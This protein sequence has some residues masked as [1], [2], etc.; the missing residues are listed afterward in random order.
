MKQSSMLKEINCKNFI[1]NPIKFSSG[2]NSI[3]GDNYSTN[4]IGKSTLLMIIDF[5]FGGN[6]YLTK[7]SGSI[8]ELGDLVFNFEFEFNSSSYFYNRG[9]Q[10]DNTIMVCDDQYNPVSEIDLK[11][12]TQRLKEMYNIENGLSFRA[13]VSP[14]SRIWGKG[15]YDVDKPIQNFSKE[16]ESAA[17]DNFI[18]LFNLFDSISKTSG[19]IKS[20]EESK[21]ILQGLHKKNYVQKVTKT[22]FQKNENEIKRIGEDINKIKDNLL[23]FTLNIEEL[24]NKELIELK[25]EKSKL[26]ENQSLVQNKIT[27][28]ELNIDRKSVKSNYFKKLSLFFENPNEEKINE[29]ESFHNK[30]RDILTREL[31]ATLEVLDEEN[32]N[33]SS[34]IEIID[35]K[36]SALLENVDSPK[37][38]VEKIY[39]LTIESNKIETVNRFYQEKINVEEDLNSLNETLLSTITDILN[40]IEE[41]INNELIRINKEIHTEKKKIPRIKLNRKSYSF[42]HSANTGTGKSYADLIEFDL[43][44][45]KLT[46]LPFI[47]HDSILFKNIEDVSVEKIIQQYNSFKKQIFIALDGINRYNDASQKILNKSS[48]IN[49]SE[50]RKLFNRDWR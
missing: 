16:P 49:L 39:D 11:T 44:I 45:L 15:N 48:V 22:E 17:V 29:I 13:M 3:L 33:F 25:T 12:Y 28:L 8:K 50:T 35:T 23:E 46:N 7:D 36:I 41:Q 43:A 20:K 32:K 24:S 27:R 42:D 34:E 6:S 47:I 26:L 19:E 40:K 4:S 21:K 18:K 1:E 14:Y 38:I 30:I 2:L 9:T 10:N 5:V 31:K 37:F